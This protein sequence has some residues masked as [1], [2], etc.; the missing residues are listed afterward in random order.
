M[1][2]SILIVLASLV[3]LMTVL[4]SVSVRLRNG[5]VAD[6][7]WGIGFVLAGLLYPAIAPVRVPVAWLMTAMLAIWGLRLSSFIW[8]ERVAGGKPED[9]R[10]A[11]FRKKWGAAANRNLF[12]FFLLQAV[13][14]VVVS[15][16]VALASSG[17]LPGL[18][19][20]QWAGLLV[21]VAA[22][23]GEWVADRQLQRFKSGSGNRGKVCDK[24]L[25]K[26]SRHPNYFFE[27]LLWV[28]LA[29]M[30]SGADLWW[31]GLASPILMLL[32]LTRVT[33]IPLAEEQSL[34]NRGEAYR[35]YQRTTSAFVPWFRK[36]ERAA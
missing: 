29:T 19:S 22:F 28:G 2:V 23:A 35:R 13:L 15:L 25:W 6:V 16:P 18:G 3:A 26:Y 14:I 5:A 11:D 12:G 1:T 24:G 8:K 4:W 36:K 10:Y 32:L 20:P 34:K 7:A 33:G 31:I 27:W 17:T 9:A 30:A 21:W